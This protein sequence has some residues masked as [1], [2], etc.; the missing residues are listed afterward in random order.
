MRNYVVIMRGR[1]PATAHPVQAV[2]DPVT[3]AE[4][5]AVIRRRLGL[6]PRLQPATPGP[7]TTHAKPDTTAKP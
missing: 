5:L 3:V 7:G 4:I 2:A 6:T 1:S